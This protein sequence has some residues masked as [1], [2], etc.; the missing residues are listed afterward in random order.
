[1]TCWPRSFAHQGANLPVL[2]RRDQRRAF[3]RACTAVLIVMMLP[4]I[5]M[6]SAANRGAACG[7][8]D[9][10]ATRIAQTHPSCPI[11]C[12]VLGRVGFCVGP[13]DPV[14]RFKCRRF[15]SSGGPSFSIRRDSHPGMIP[16]YGRKTANSLRT[17]PWHRRSSRT[18]MPGVRRQRLPR[19][20]GGKVTTE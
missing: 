2:D 13:R 5:S 17:L 12:R 4:G 18:G 10:V 6:D 7:S 20:C 14:R 9:P 3:T 8:S 11:A 16:N 19:G 15:V 1:M